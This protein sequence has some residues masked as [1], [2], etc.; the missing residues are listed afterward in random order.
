MDGERHVVRLGGNQPLDIGGVAMDQI[1]DVVTPVGH[2]AA[3]LGIAQ[4][5]EG[6]VVEL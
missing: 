2:C 3:H 4:H 6:G 5:G 1:I